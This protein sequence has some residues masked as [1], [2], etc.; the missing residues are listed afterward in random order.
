[1]YGMA[2]MGVAGEA[3]SNDVPIWLKKN[4][5]SSTAQVCPSFSQMP[6]LTRAPF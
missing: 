3:A 5:C 6:T 2:M 4:T 1:M